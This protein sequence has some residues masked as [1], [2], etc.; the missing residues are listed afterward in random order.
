SD[1]K[2]KATWKIVNT[3]S[4]KKKETDLDISQLAANTQS[5]KECLNSINQHLIGACA[6]RNN[7]NTANT[8][9]VKHSNQTIFL[10]STSPSE[11][12]NIIRS[13]KNTAAVGYDDDDDDDEIPIK[14][15]KHC[16]MQ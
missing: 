14:L 7:L 12:Y 8:R 11:V 2:M 13:L 4:G 9:L 10:Q 15:I 5:S 1:N 3:I 16:S 6:G